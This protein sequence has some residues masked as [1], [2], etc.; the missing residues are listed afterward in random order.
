MTVLL[1]KEPFAVVFGKKCGNKP[2]SAKC[3]SREKKVN[4]KQ[5]SV[6][7]LVE[8]RTGNMMS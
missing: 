2:P 3:G 8:M 5:D 6:S 1:S 4:A 7:I